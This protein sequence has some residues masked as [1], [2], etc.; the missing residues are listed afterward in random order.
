[1]NKDFQEKYD[2]MPFY[3]KIYNTVTA[4]YYMSPLG[5]LFNHEF[6][7]KAWE[8]YYEINKE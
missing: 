5:W 7:L 1:M 3:K 4:V 8:L 6:Y 2:Q